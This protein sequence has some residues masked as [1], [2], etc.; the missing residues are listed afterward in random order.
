MNTNSVQFFKENPIE[1][2]GKSTGLILAAWKVS[3]SENIGKI[4]RL[5]HNIGAASVLFIVGD[6]QHRLSKVKK[7]AGFSFDQQNWA[8]ISE[9]EFLDEVLA[10]YPLT[11]LETCDGASDLFASKIPEKTVLL[12]GSESKGIPPHIIKKSTQQVYIP[13][14][15]GCKSMNISN[16]LSV[17]AFEWFRQQN[18]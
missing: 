5:A 13:M 1:S 2:T 6:E 18:Y 16:A 9:E 12:A 8:F 4:I 11:V 15:G 10:E 17:A 3:N 14:P 7:T